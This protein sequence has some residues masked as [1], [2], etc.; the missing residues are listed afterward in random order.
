MK[1]AISALVAVFC[2]VAGGVGGHFLK[3]MLGG[4]AGGEG[5]AS[6]DAAEA[7]GENAPGAS[8]KA[9][10]RDKDGKTAHGAAPPEDV[11]FYSFSREFVVPIL[12]DSRVESLVILNI[13]LETDPDI[14]QELFALEPKLRDNIMTT[15]I[16][17]SND[18]NTFDTITDVDSYE[19]IRAM[20]LMNLQNVVPSGIHNVLILDMAKQN[21]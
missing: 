9:S 20:I 11:V 13:N 8:K 7:D 10:G 12:R 2:I 16:K 5:Y 21:L 17:L 19:S 6:A 4:S 14:S 15:L 18:G 3:S 1:H